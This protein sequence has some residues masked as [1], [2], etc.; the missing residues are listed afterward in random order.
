MADSNQVLL[1]DG[2]PLDREAIRRELRQE[3]Q[4]IR[5]HEACTSE[6]VDHALSANEFRLVITEYRL[7]ATSGLEVLLSVKSRQP[8]CPV[9]MFTA[10][11]DVEVAVQAMKNGL[12]DYVLKK[13]GQFP[14]LISS[15]RA[16]LEN[17]PERKATE[18]RQDSL[19]H[20]LREVIAAADEFSSCRTADEVF[21][22]A[23][24]L[25]QEKLGI[26][27]CAIFVEDGQWLRGTFGI[28]TQ[29]EIRE[30][31]DV[32]F[33]KSEGA[34][35]QFGLISTDDLRWSVVR[36]PLFTW[37]GE[38]RTNP[39]ADW[40]AVTPITAIQSGTR[41][42]GI[43]LNDTAISGSPMDPVRQEILAV[44][45][46][47]LGDI[48]ELKQIED[49]LRQS[50]EH[51]R[52]LADNSPVGIWHL[53]PEGHTTYLNSAMAE[54]LEVSSAQEL[55]GETY[56]RFIGPKARPAGEDCP[57]GEGRPTASEMVIVGKRSGQRTVL[58]VSSPIFSPAGA[59]EGVIRTFVDITGQ[60]EA[61]QRLRES[62]REI[63]EIS[64]REQ[65]RIG[66]D[67]HDNLGQHLT[68]TAFL[69]KGL[70]Q[71]LEAESLPEAKDAEQISD[72]VNQAI[73]KT[74]SLAR[75]L[76][77]VELESNGLVA[78]LEEL[79][80]YMEDLFGVPCAFTYDRSFTL[81]D[82][83]TATHLYRIVQEAATNAGKH[84]RAGR[85]TISL[86]DD[87]EAI[88]VRVEDDGVGLQTKEEDAEGMGLRIMRYRSQ[89]IGASLD[90]R[91]AEGGGTAV[92]CR[93][94]LPESR[95]VE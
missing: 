95:R 79:T 44:F 51:Y 26:E 19:L 42:K 68:G 48:V 13:D 56:H 74:R 73:E 45:C 54:M 72:L 69:A 53:S 65:M 91:P 36:E 83:T 1:V 39:D 78:A 93:C 5:I 62:E 21:R 17:L 41:S 85:V 60:R 59:L 52:V 6:E 57:A 11:G 7:P 20:G 77:P 9:I 24:E 16:V 32:S 43:F 18:K 2:S 81:D 49:E 28:T 88:T 47:L 14:V 31:D 75:S 40:L 33:R 10:S 15:V 66:Q 55:E 27:R 8:E 86:E 82:N 92:V 35:E 3:F 46:S 30:L 64:G 63:L 37:N 94:P 67:L 89:M 61:E 22:H 4:E 80:Q 50:K 71:K 70:A 34:T 12:T 87:D 23:I 29:G 25:A 76:F 38:R 58:G 90:L 84:S